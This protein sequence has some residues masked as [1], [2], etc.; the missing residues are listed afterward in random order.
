M[1]LMGKIM[2]RAIF[3]ICTA[4]GNRDYK[5]KSDV[6]N[7]INYILRQ[8]KRSD[9]DIWNSI[10]TYNESKEGI[11]KDFYRLKRLYDKTDGLQ[12][13]HLILSWALVRISQ[14]KNYENLLNR[15]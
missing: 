10:G 11:I 7:V 13:K 9:D 1:R 4:N 5:K 14:E 15:Q 2:K 8:S 3:K 12:I 6:K